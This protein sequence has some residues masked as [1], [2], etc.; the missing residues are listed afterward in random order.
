[1]SYYGF[2]RVN[3]GL[4]QSQ[5]PNSGKCLR[6]RQLNINGQVGFEQ[7]SQL[8]EQQV[9]LEHVDLI[10]GISFLIVRTCCSGSPIRIMLSG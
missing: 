4:P 1:M 6:S 2:I 3:V 8:L 5:T 9:E 10:I 7:V